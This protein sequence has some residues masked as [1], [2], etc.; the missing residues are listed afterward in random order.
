[1]HQLKLLK[2]NNQKS[3][4]KSSNIIKS[5]PNYQKIVDRFDDLN[6]NY[7]KRV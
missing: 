2:I 1:M 4:F 3:K 5:L 7:L 6:I